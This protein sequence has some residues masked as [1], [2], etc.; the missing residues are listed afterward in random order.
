M[1]GVSPKPAMEILLVEDSP[2]DADLMV[3]ALKDGTLAAHITVL[4]DGEKAMDYLRRPG[5]RP[6][7]LLVLDLHLPRMNGFE[8]LQEINDDIRLRRI[9]VVI[10]T[11]SEHEK[12]IP[13]AYDLYA[14]CCVT[15]P[16]DPEQF[17][18]AVWTIEQFWRNVA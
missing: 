10:L 16:F 3:E 1:S 18:L 17:A 12:T 7:H 4:D 13:N 14:V 11:S 15:K 5:A 8:V 6:P 9:P 2:D